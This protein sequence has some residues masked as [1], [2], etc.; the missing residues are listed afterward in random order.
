[1][2]LTSL[3]RHDVQEI[4]RASEGIPSQRSSARIEN[5]RLVPATTGHPVSS[6]LHSAGLV[7]NK[8]KFM[9]MADMVEV[10]WQLLQTPAA[11]ATLATLRVGTRATV[12][13]EVATLFGFECY[14]PDPQGRG[15][16]QRVVF[17]PDEQR[18]AGRMKT[19]CVAVIEGRQR[20][21]REHLQVHSFYPAISPADA[22]ALLLAVRR[23]L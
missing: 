5:G 19:T 14:L 8:T 17:T 23:H 3:T 10:L 21:D 11:T 16:V 22:Q 12:R 6:H 20:A 2:N 4:L 15:T 1:V 13:S 7:E 9:S 18:R